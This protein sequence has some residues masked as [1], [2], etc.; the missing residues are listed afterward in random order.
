M[1]ITGLAGR[2]LVKLAFNN[3]LSNH[4]KNWKDFNAGKRLDAMSHRGSHG[5]FF[6]GWMGPTSGQLA[7]NQNSADR[8]FTICRQG[9]TRRGFA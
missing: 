3:R 6:L 5:S 4:N 8:G 9:V 7:C 2:R 1:K